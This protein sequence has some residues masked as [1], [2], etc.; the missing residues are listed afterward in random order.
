MP[1]IKII[2]VD[3]DIHF[4]HNIVKRLKD[5]GFEIVHETNGENALKKIDKEKFDLCIL[6]SM[7]PGMDGFLLAS[8]IR[9]K[10]DKIPI[11][12]FSSKALDEDII[13][14]FKSGGDDYLGKTA[15]MQELL[16]RLNVFLKRT[17]RLSGDKREV[18]IIQNLTFEYNELCLKS[19]EGK[20]ELISQKEADLLKFL[21]QNPNKTLKREEILYHVWGKDDYFLGRSMDVFIVKLR[22]RLK[23][24]PG[25][26]IETIH[27]IGFKFILPV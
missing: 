9:S 6:E 5:E 1:E 18:F 26:E 7:I 16:L 11:L 12:F 2:Y 21:C 22:K 8:A 27:G 14:G 10:D 20:V 15:C 25:V 24:T 19:K 23:K 13:R 4:A 17:R 3:N